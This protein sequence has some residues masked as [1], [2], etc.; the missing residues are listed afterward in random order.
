MITILSQAKQAGNMKVEV[1]FFRGIKNEDTMF[2]L[3]I[4]KETW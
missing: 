4:K 2:Q 3:D 1:G